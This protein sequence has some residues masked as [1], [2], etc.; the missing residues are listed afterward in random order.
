MQILHINCFAMTALDY[1]VDSGIFVN[2]THTACAKKYVA[3]W[4][5]TTILYQQNGI[6]SHIIY[7]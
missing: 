3:I 1:Q 5:T 7:V 2:S 6:K 4:K